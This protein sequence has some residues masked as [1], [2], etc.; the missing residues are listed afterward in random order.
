MHIP[1]I[2]VVDSGAG[3]LTVTSE[4]RKQLPGARYI[5]FADTGYYPYGS[6]TELELLLRVSQIIERVTAQ[7][8]IDIAVI[9]CNTASTVVLDALRS[10][11]EIPFVG[12]VPA[13][14]PA[15]RLTRS[16]TI[17]VLATSGTVSRSYTAALIKEFASNCAVYLHGS[18]ALVHFAE[19]KLCGQK[20]DIQ[21]ISR[22]LALLLTQAPDR[23]IDTVVLACTH[24]PLLRHELAISGPGVS[25]WVDSGEAIARRVEHWV[26][27]LR[28]AKKDVPSQGTIPG[29][30]LTTATRLTYTESSLNS[31][32]GPHQCALIS[33]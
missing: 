8:D 19:A 22:E 5:Y 17:G 10:R 7:F 29:T 11:F 32:L 28:L 25:H 9:A 14:K 30:F 23:A 26:D 18:P 12:V 1:T 2:L 20:P 6:K 31:L 4:I 15:A 3:G 27:H 21:E 13:I 24:F 33:L 16:G